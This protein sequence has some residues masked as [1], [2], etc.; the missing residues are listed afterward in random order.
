MV[1]VRPSSRV[2]AF[3][4]IELIV[5]IG[6][7]GVLLSLLL[8]AVQIVRESANRTSCSNNLRQLGLASH[9]CND[10]YGRLPPGLGFFPRPPTRGNAFFHLLPFLEQDNLYTDSAGFAENN[11]VYSKP[12][13]IFVC[14]SDPSARADG[15]A[16]DNQKKIWGA[17]S[18]AGNVQVFA[19]VGP[20]GE[21]WDPE[22]RT[23]LTDITDGQ[24]NTILFAEK[25]ARCTNNSF[26]EGGNFWAYWVQGPTVRPLHPGFAISWT[27]YSTGPH[28]KFQTRPRPYMGHCDPTLASTA[29]LAGIQVCMADGSVRTVSSGVSGKTWWAACTP[30][31]GEV[32]G[33]D[34]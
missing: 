18:Y 6:I 32:L 11:D 15:T 4:L 21:L 20:N 22:G 14:P 31:G 1:P 7:I 8:P 23:R 33:S 9:H 19:K 26:P 5:V 16:L 29:H 27:L 34:W 13:K 17:C 24:S 30:Q 10:H 12:V 25:Y 3:T 2:L 28:S